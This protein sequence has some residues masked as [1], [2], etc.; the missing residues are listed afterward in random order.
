VA[1]APDYVSEDQLRDYCRVHDLDDEALHPL[2][3][4]A[5][6]RA[7]DHHTNRQFGKVDAPVERI[8]HPWPDDE[9][10][11]WCVDIDDLMD[12]AGL[13]V[14]VADATVATFVLEPRNAAP[15]GRPWTRLVFTGDSEV[16]PSSTLDDVS[17][18]APWGWTATPDTVVQATLLQASRLTK[19]RDAPFGVAG[20]P[21]MGSELRLLARVDPDVAVVLADYMRPRKVG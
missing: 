6:S 2:A 16:R 13:V 9:R 11:Y 12:S 10:A 5:A 3:R 18:L 21:D 4:T 17:V 1:W 7:V 19:R 14:K 8:Y 15:D 20:S